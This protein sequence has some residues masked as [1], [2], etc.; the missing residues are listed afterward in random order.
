[1]EADSTAIDLL[2]IFAS[3][4]AAE[5]NRQ[6]AGVGGNLASAA[7]SNLY[8]PKSNRRAGLVLSQFALGTAE[9]ISANVA[10]YGHASRPRNP[11]AKLTIGAEFGFRAFSR[12]Q[13]EADTVRARPFARWLP[14]KA[15]PGDRRR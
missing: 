11:I 4:A 15:M 14:N 6:K 8:F 12:Q 9:R 3:R 2:T 1:M 7:I 10:H 5:L 13:L